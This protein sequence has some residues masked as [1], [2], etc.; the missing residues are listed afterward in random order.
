MS[1]AALIT[2]MKA[3]LFPAYLIQVAVIVAL[4]CA[5]P[6]YAQDSTRLA[7][8]VVQTKSGPVKV[9][10]LASLS[11]PWGMAFLPDGR[12]L[13]TEKPGRLR[14]YSQGKLS[15]PISGLPKID[16]RA[17]GGLLD[18]EID[19]NFAQN[20]L[21]YFYFSEAAESQPDVKRDNGDP[22]LGEYQDYDDATLKGGAVARGRLVGNALQE[23]KVIWRQVPKMIGRGHFGGRL[24][25]APDGKLFITSGD[26]QRFEPAQRLSSN[27]GKVIRINPDGSVPKDNPFVATKG[28]LPEIWSRGH[29]N[30]LGAAINPVS[31][32]LWINEMG[33]MHGDELNIPTA[34]KNYGWPLV[35]NGDNYDGSRIPDHETMPKFT[36]PVYYWHPAVS[37]S[38]LT[39]YTGNLFAGWRDN[40]LLGSF[41]A[42]ALVRLT[43]KGDKVVAEERIALRRRV[44]DVA[45]APDGSVWLLTDAKEGELLRLSPAVR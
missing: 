39:F 6:T 12:L 18:V 31:K 37:P 17:Q 40:A 33:P 38:G 23:V 32:Q 7:G 9:E 24:A 8:E 10:K 5:V 15:E 11:E 4:F 2:P 16:Y 41:N 44:R 20:G 36:G 45:Q 42:E 43:L 21:V 27:L 1:A 22:R 14:I 3:R 35:S 13:V 29:R 30:A 25:F 26:R 19:P 34:G 28:A